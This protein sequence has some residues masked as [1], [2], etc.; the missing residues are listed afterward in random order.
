M[1][2][3]VSVPSCVRH[4]VRRTHAVKYS[5]LPSASVRYATWSGGG[6]SSK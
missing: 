4:S 3:S 2:P 6:N 1:D 5:Q